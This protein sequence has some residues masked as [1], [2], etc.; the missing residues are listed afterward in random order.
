M[1]LNKVKL[2]VFGYD[3]RTICSIKN[4]VLLEGTLKEELF[5]LGKYYDIYIAGLLGN[6]RKFKGIN[7]TCIGRPVKW[8]VFL[9]VIQQ[10]GALLE[11]H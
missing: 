6:T 9:S 10:T 7:N 2:Q 5:R 1:N 4:T 3:N 11:N 8:S